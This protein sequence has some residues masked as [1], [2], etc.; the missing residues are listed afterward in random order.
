MGLLSHYFRFL[1][2][3]TSRAE[4]ALDEV[5]LLRMLDAVEGDASSTRKGSDARASVS[6]LDGATAKVNELASLIAEGTIPGGRSFHQLSLY[7]KKSVLIN[8]ELEY[9]LSF[10]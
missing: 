1:L 8:R 10:P 2:P 7:E 6:S 9:V 5:P 4:D 3:L